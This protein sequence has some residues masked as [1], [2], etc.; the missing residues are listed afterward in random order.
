MTAKKSVAAVL[1]DRIESRIFHH[2]RA[3]GDVEHRPG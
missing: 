1:T 2:S 3:E